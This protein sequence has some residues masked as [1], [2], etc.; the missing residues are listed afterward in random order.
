MLGGKKGI[1]TLTNLQLKGVGFF[2]MCNL[3]LPLGI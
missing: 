3:L 1:H 2:S